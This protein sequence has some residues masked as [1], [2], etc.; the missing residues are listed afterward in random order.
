M[1]YLCMEQQRVTFSQFNKRVNSLIAA[2]YSLGLKK[3]D[4]IGVLSWNCLEY[5]DIYGAAMKGGFVASPFNPRLQIDEL[6]YI[7][8]YS[9]AEV[10]FV[11]PEFT[12][13]A[14]Q[15]KVSSETRQTLYFSG[16]KS[17]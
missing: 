12:A 11:G 14:D 3:G 10:L 8:N 17:R 16:R 4:R 7:I 13:I 5:T 9:E 6:D 2:L 15:L 1:K